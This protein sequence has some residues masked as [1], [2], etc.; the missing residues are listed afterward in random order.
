MSQVM[1]T[2]GTIYDCLIKDERRMVL[3]GVAQRYGDAVSLISPLPRRI[4]ERLS[5]RRWTLAF[6]D[7]RLGLSHYQRT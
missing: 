2:Q 3:V 7:Q 6:V 4:K 5:G 1:S